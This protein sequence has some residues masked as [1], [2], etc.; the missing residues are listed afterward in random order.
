MRGT[1][2]PAEEARAAGLV[3]VTVPLSRLA[4]EANARLGTLLAV[5]DT[6][7][8]MAKG[9]LRHAAADHLRATQSED[10]D[11]FISL[12]SSSQVQAG[13]SQ[14]LASLGGKKKKGAE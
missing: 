11:R 12:V 5:P 9:D 3:D 8:A 2:L 1:L 7:R 13:I 6:A 10:L 14:Y 4:D